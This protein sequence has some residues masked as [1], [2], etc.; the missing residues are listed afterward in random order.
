MSRRSSSPQAASLIDNLLEK[1][2]HTYHMKMKNSPAK[3]CASF[4]CAIA[5]AFGLLS[6]SHAVT[7]DVITPSNVSFIDDTGVFGSPD[8]SNIINGSG[9]SSPIG[10]TIESTNIPSLSV[11]GNIDATGWRR[12]GGNLTGLF[13][14]FTLQDPSTVSGILLA[15]YFESGGPAARGMNT[16]TFQY[17]DDEGQNYYSVGTL[18]ATQGNGGFQL[19]DLG[20]TLTG[21]TNVRF[22]SI[23]NFGADGT[24]NSNIVGMN[25]VRF[26]NAVPEPSAALLG[27]LGVLALLRRRR[28]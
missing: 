17:S 21:V 1:N 27:G 22:S 26:V 11:T 9:V 15:N 6:L 25:E 4:T 5:S 18:S 12:N 23:T 14:T 8:I 7:Y 20:T 28:A 24:G 19:I 2:H 3:Q 10:V 13:F 16:F